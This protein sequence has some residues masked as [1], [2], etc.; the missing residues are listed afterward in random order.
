VTQLRLYE[1][2]AAAR[3]GRVVPKTKFYE[4]G[5]VSAAVRDRLVADVQRITWAYKL[6]DGTIHLRG[7]ASV[8]EIQV[9]VIE[10][11][12]TDV[13]KDVLAAIDRLVPFP[14]IL[15]IHRVHDTQRLIRMTAAHKELG[16]TRPRLSDYFTTGWQAADSGRRPLPPAIDLPGLYAALLGPMLPIE[17]RPGEHLADTTDR[18]AQ[19]RK[20]EREI[21]VLERR[22]RTEPQFNRKVAIR[23]QLQER[24]AARGALTDPTM[25]SAEDAQWRS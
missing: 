2:P 17:T 4:H 23:R 14:T 12:G 3:F 13:G 21:A 10:A 25:P 11:K 15:E 22:L 8:P 24:T 7:D 9:F 16:G 18:L 19:I 5:L 6:A 20:V 1:W